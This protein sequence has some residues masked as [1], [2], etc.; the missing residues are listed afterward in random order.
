MVLFTA[1]GEDFE[2]FNEFLPQFDDDNRRRCFFI[3]ILEDEAYEDDEV[4][5]VFLVVPPSVDGVTAEPSLATV[6]IRDPDGK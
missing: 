3:T 4:F 2:E 5:R 6:Q 1:Q